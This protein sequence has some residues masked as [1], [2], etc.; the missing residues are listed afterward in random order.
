MR[1]KL[2]EVR[3]VDEPAACE[4]ALG[5]MVEGIATVAG[6]KPVVLAEAV[7]AMRRS[8]LLAACRPVALGGWGVGLEP[9]AAKATAD[10]LRRVGRADL[11]VGRVL[12]GH[13]N[14]A[15]LVDLY[16][17]PPARGRLQRALVEGALLA[18]WGADGPVPVTL[19]GGSLHG[20]KRFA[21]GLGVVD[22][23]LVTARTA[24][25]VQLVA[26]DARNVAR[27][28]P[29]TWATSGMRA[30][31]SGDFD[32]TGLAIG[33]A[34]LVGS[35][36]DLFR[37]PHFLGGIWRYLAVQL[38]GLEALVEAARD[39]LVDRG[40]H[41]H[42][43]QAHRL[44]QALVATETARLWVYDAAIR[45]EADG[46]GQDAADYAV[47]ARLAVERLALETIASV[48]RSLGTR[49]FFEAHPVDALRRDL[50]FYLRQ[51]D[52]DGMLER[53]AGRLAERG[54]PVGELWRPA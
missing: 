2:S 14:A 51:A 39:D 42:P 52:P 1:S 32:V 21:S 3:T 11:S 38:G 34:D 49:A 23:A 53:S 13:V 33:D 41:H 37:E 5:A 20:V 46:A 35:P 9:A 10:L 16:A 17:R 26:V 12:E 25:D 43:H 48:E 7:A 40:R 15:K 6:A 54:V 18:V 31:A 19:D 24:G 29:A 4:R 8:G 28:A 47:L 45:V 50:A 44:G 22:L 27:H 30:S 36:G